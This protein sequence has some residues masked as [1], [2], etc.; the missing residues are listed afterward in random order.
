MKGLRL[1]ALLIL[2]AVLYQGG[3]A[4]LRSPALQ[5]KEFEVRGNDRVST[6][7]LVGAT[8]IEIGDHLI[9]IS[10]DRVSQRLKEL[11]WVAEVRVE[12]ILPSSLKLTVEEREPALMVRA[13]PASYL[14][15]SDG[16]VLQEGEG[17]L[18]QIVLP[19]TTSAVAGTSIDSVEFV[20]ATRILDSLPESIR[21]KVV[22]IEAPA[23]DQ[24]QIET[25][26]GPA[27]YYGA[28]EQ[29]NEK[30]FAVESL[31]DGNG[32]GATGNLVLDVRVPSRPVTRTS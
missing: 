27:I 24:I 1:V 18:V 16:L 12:R 19:A 7:E 3:Q 21:S 14:T 9:G 22:L 25:A 17:D 2:G 29:L 32:L 13:G 6:E 26:G 11:P 31:L 4:I 10:T 15:D 8:G 30:N 5:L 20:H 23:I 28:A